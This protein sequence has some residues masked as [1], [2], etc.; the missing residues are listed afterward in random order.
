[1]ALI[2]FGG[3]ITA[4]SG[5]IAGNTFARNRFGY[6]SRARTK[7]VNPKSSRQSE[8]RSRMMLLAEY[9]HEAPMSDAE[10][11][12]WGT[13]AAAISKKNR[14]GDPVKLTGFN[15]FIRSNAAR[16]AAGAALVEA[17][18]TVLSLPEA[19]VTLAASGD[20]G[21]QLL[22]VAFDNSKEWA[23]ETGGYLLIEMGRP[24]LLTRNF[25]NGPWRIAGAIAGATGSPPTSPQ[26]I[27]APF[28]L[29]TDQKIWV[30]ANVVRADA[31]M[32]NKF[33]APEFIVGGL[34]PGYKVSGTLSPDATC[35]YIL[36]GAFNGKAYYKRADN[37]YK[38]WWDGTTTWYISV[39]LGTPGTGHWKRIN[40]AIA[41]AYTAVEPNTGAATVAAGLCA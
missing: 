28:T 1:M 18:P 35:N 36:G 30:R 38:I 24:Q 12:A 21:T 11:G 32:S 34:L 4:M 17:G 15:H 31:R 6:Y 37:A 23:N 3:G 8:A 14:L 13:Y 39:V 40:A 26:T 27:V 29:T 10:R 20:S 5:S 7:P 22:T 16:F 25:F 19:D 41:G 9:W 2:K 33:L